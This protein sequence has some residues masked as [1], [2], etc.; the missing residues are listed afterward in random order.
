MGRGMRQATATFGALVLG[1]LALGGL[2]GTASAHPGGLDAEGCHVCHTNCVE[3]YGIPYESRHCHGGGSSS[4]PP[5]G[6]SAPPPPPPPPPADTTAPDAPVLVGPVSNL[7]G[8]VT[9]TVT[10]E[11]GSVI[12]VTSNVAGELLSVP[13][14]GALQPLE[15]ALTIGAHALSITAVDGA[16][17]V[18][19]ALTTEE[20]YLGPT[21]PR[22]RKLRPSERASLRL[23]LRSLNA[24]SARVSLSDGQV[25]EG[26]FD[27][28][29][30]V[31]EFEVPDGKY[32]VDAV[33]ADS[34]GALSRRSLLDVSVDTVAPRLS[35]KINKQK[36]EDGELN[37]AV[38]AEE[39]SKVRVLSA[40]A[41]LKKRYRAG[42]SAKR[43]I[44]NIDEGTYRLRV[45]ATDAAGNVMTR[46]AT[47]TIA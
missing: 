27:D 38:R 15:F 18:S 45:I 47:L 22:L 23:R 1:F 46:R 13:A 11:A 17:N 10:A 5:A 44:R 2:A 41:K 34:H 42:S 28:G 19:G 12:T 37:L 24:A 35:I 40:K 33:A 9:C 43:F 39:G 16:G 21:A 4:P 31:A 26:L 32:S 14:S 30:L 36:A 7:A 3:K 29:V 8:T 25:V 20:A 6:P